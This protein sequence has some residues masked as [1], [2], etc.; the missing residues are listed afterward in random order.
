MDSLNK[1]IKNMT[2][3]QN[4]TPII[5]G[6]NVEGNPTYITQHGVYKRNMDSIEFSIFLKGT[7]DDTID[8][9][10]VIG[11][12]PEINKGGLTACNIG[13]VQK[14][15]QGYVPTGSYIDNDS[16]GIRLEYTHSTGV[17]WHIQGANVR[18]SEFSIVISGQYFV[19]MI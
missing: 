19:N 12:L 9:N 16:T 4:F 6:Q 17:H 2:L 18:V 8:G 7:F 15:I 14:W 11:G 5:K 3:R 1:R 13:L 10:V